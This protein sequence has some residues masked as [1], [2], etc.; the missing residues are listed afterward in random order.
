MG[1]TPSRRVSTERRRS[2]KMRCVRTETLPCRL[3][4]RVDDDQREAIRRAAELS[5]ESMSEWSRDVLAEAARQAR[6]DAAVADLLRRS[7]HR[8]MA[9]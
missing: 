1:L 9:A 5:G 4:I 6:I 3:G 8:R 2:T 7:Q